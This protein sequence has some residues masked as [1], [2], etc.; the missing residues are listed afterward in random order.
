MSLVG[1]CRTGRGVYF[2][3]QGCFKRQPRAAQFLNAQR[4]FRFSRA[5]RAS[6][7]PH[8]LQKYSAWSTKLITGSLESRIFWQGPLYAAVLFGGIASYFYY[9][10]A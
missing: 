5:L 1:G 8:Y 6:A 10:G 9:V 2:L 3:G 4:Y 7:N